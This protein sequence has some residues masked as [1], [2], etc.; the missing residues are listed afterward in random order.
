MNIE[1]LHFAAIEEKAG[2]STHFWVKIDSS[3]GV[4]DDFPTP[5]QARSRD[6]H[7]LLELEVDAVLDWLATRQAAHGLIN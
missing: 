2:G 1:K 7:Y 5:R 4:P 3:D 6:A